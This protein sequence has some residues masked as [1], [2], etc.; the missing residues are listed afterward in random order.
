MFYKRDWLIFFVITSLIF[1]AAARTALDTDLWWHLRA[2]E[3]TITQGFPLLEDHFSFTRMGTAWTNHSWLS[4]VIYYLIFRMTGFVGVG[5]LS[6]LAATISMALLYFQMSGKPI[7][8]AFLLVLGTLVAAVVWSPRPQVFSLVLF[9]VTGLILYVYKW[10][11]RNFLG[12]LPIV[13]IL[14]SNLHGGYPLGLILIGVTIAGEMVNRWI[15]PNLTK[16]M[17]WKEIGLI[18][19]IGIIS[20][21]VVIINPNGFKMWTIPFQTIDVKALQQ[22]IQEWASPDFH[23]LFQQPFLWLLFATIAAIAFS[24]HRADAVDVLL[25]I[26]FGYMG[27]TSRRNFGPFALVATPVLSRYLWL[28]WKG[29]KTY[30]NTVSDWGSDPTPGRF[31]PR[32]QKVINL[33]LV[34]VLFFTALIKVYLVNHPEFITQTIQATLPAGAVEWVKENKP[35]GN[36]LNEYNWGGYLSWELRDHLIFI[37]GRT[38]LYGDCGINEWIQLVGAGEFWNEILDGYKIGFILVDP[39]RPIVNV[40]LRNGWAQTYGDAISIVLVRSSVP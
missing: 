18:A 1:L 37:D 40:L 16:E 4:Q 38:D 20:G 17:T 39:H 31:I 12:W 10:R 9:A 6:A 15:H 8:R 21:L 27:L 11:K 33:V 3:E 24:G 28:A 7:V 30:E 23:E 22:L 14:W 29:L 19:L 36:M 5:I 25:V 13:F 26:V 2:G 34:G 35:E 32:W